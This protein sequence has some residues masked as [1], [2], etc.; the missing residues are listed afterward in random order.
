MI[1]TNGYLV[2]T[3]MKFG[4]TLILLTAAIIAFS[5]YPALAQVF[6]C[7]GVWT[8]NS[9]E[10]PSRIIESTT[11]QVAKDPKVLENQKLQREKLSLIYQLKA[12]SRQFDDYK[13][14]PPPEVKTAED[15]CGLESTLV[16]DCQTRVN[17]VRH[18]LEQR[19]T[20][21]AKLKV[22]QERLELEKSKSNEPTTQVNITNETNYIRVIP[23]I[24]DCHGTW[25]TKPCIRPTPKP[26]I[27]TPQ[28]QI[29]N[30]IKGNSIRLRQH[31]PTR[32]HY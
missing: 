23:G 26:I 13:N 28:P 15:Y 1:A 32:K 20:E 16:E 29:E 6:N 7:N 30:K 3:A 25:Q 14:L 12:F 9:C 2:I 8:S 18:S 11:E 5:D 22:E 31:K 19:E 24:Y 27:P 17:E 4:L 21:K 10:N